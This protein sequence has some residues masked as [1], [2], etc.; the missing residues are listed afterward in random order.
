MIVLHFSKLGEDTIELTNEQVS[1]V[2]NTM[3]RG[4]YA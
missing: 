1:C 4:K 3:Q 2:Y